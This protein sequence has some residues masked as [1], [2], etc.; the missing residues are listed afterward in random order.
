MTKKYFDLEKLQLGQDGRVEL[1]AALADLESKAG[2]WGFGWSTSNINC[3]FESND[4][5]CSNP[6][7]CR[8]STNGED[9]ANAY[10]CDSGNNDFFCSN[11]ST[12]GGA[13]NGLECT[14][15]YENCNSHTSN[16]ETC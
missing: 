16:L 8:A 2:G 7:R 10:A 3:N 14:N 5:V 6:W 15:S 9:C 1:P 13:V 12:C 11:N 4:E